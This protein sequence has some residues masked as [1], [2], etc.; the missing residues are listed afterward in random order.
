MYIIWASQCGELLVVRGT[1]AGSLAGGI[2]DPC[3]FCLS[4]WG[5]CVWN[6]IMNIYVFQ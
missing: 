1:A 2:A 3:L 6:G 5:L 4:F